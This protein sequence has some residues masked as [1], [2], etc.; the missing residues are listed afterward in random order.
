L[1]AAY[2]HERKFLIAVGADRRTR[3]DDER[4]ALLSAAL[5]K[6]LPAVVKPWTTPTTHPFE[7]ALRVFGAERQAG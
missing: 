7:M 6:R 2:E 4:L 1:R 3:T 5:R